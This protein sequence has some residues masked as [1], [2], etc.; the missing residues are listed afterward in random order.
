[1]AEVTLLSKYISGNLFYPV[2]LP[3]V[4][5]NLAY[6]TWCSRNLFLHLIYLLI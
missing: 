2:C 3:S 5:I 1:M 6:I 4:E